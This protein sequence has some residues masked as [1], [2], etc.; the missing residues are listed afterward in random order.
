MVI[1]CIYNDGGRDKAYMETNDIRFIGHGVRDCVA[2]SLAIVT[3]RPYAEI[4]HALADINKSE[5][6]RHSAN[7][8]VYVGR[9]SFWDYTAA[10]GLIYV[11][12]PPVVLKNA[13]LPSGKLILNIRAHSVAMID[14]VL[15][16]TY[17]CS[18][19]GKVILKGYWMKKPERAAMYNVCNITTGLPINRAPL[20]FEQ[21]ENMA[22]LM[23]LNY[24]KQTIINPVI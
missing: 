9:K 14:G 7:F 23:L 5:G 13:S 15:H 16:D 6:R 10:L 22:R 24:K 18:P 3:D 12:V 2:R 4:W 19:G 11:E 8:G 1:D 20:N 17:N 21:A